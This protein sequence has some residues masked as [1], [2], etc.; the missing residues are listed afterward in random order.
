MEKR[1]TDIQVE[2]LSDEWKTLLKVRYRYRMLDNKVVQKTNEI[3]KGADGVAG[4]LYH[5]HQR[6]VVLTKQF[7]MPAFMNNHPDGMLLEVCA[8]LLDEHDPA[9]GMKR[10]IME[11][12]G[13]HV[14]EVHKIMEAYSSPGAITEKIHYFIAPYNASMKA[15]EGG[16]VEDEKED[17]EVIEL[18]FEEAYQ[19]IEN[20]RIKDAKTITLLQYARIHLF[21]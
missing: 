9:E 4:L 1:A 8:G 2:T 14:T 12:T 17:I 20:G 15:A 11:E 16:G 19:M 18:P 3:Y 7:R 21:K 5:P 6:S 10:E 13:Y